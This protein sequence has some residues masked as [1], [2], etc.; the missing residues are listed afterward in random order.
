MV[1][2]SALLPRTALAHGERD[3]PSEDK[4][5]VPVVVVPETPPEEWYSFHY[6]FTGVTQYHPSFYSA[7]TPP[8]TATASA[9]TTRARRPSSRRSIAT[10]ACGGEAELLFNPEMSGGRGLS[11]TLGVAAFPNGIVY[12]VGDPAPAVYLA[13]L[14]ISQ[15]FGLGGGKVINEAA[16][17]ELAGT[18][19]QNQLAI[20]VGR[21]SVIDVVDANR[22]AND[23]TNQ[24]LNWALMASGAYDY[25]A[26]TRGYTWGV[27]GQSRLRLVVGSRRHRARARTTRTSR[28]STG[29]STRVAG[30]LG[31]VRGALLRRRPARCVES[32]PLSTRPRMGS[33]QQCARQPP[34]GAKY[35]NERRRYARRRAHE[36]RLRA[37][38]GATTQPDPRR[39]HAP[40]LERR[41]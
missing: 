7:F 23:A 2:L 38:D 12:R 11:K 5:A 13:R 28:R 39:F 41:T 33:Y 34:P 20:T 18:R 8:R 27:L 31:R 9:R 29:A 21:L 4:P 37:L 1:A 14:A 24:F 36:V 40:Q 25:P 15:T 10:H 6:Q 16:P 17:N 30:S 35:P 22:Y 26:D 32:A 3:L 19:D